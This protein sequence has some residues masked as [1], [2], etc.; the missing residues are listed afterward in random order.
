MSKQKIRVK[1][2][3]SIN[4]KWWLKQFPSQIPTWGECEFVF[5]INEKNYDWVVVY[6]DLPRIKDERFSKRTEKLTCRKDH[7]LLVTTEPPSIKSYGKIYVEQFGYVL[8]SHEDWALKH[9]EKIFSQ[10]ALIWFYGLGWHDKAVKKYD[11]MW[12][13]VDKHIKTE[14]ISTVCSSKQ[15]KHTLHNL[16][17][18]FTCELKKLIPELDIYGHGVKVINDKADA[19]DNYKYHIAIENYSGK[20]HWTEKLSDPFLGLC[21][22]FYYGATN[23]EDYF[24]KESFIE[25]DIYDIEKS[26]K[27]I[28]EAIKNNEYEKRL[29]QIKQAQK[30]VLNRYN[31]FVTVAKIIE[32]KN[33]KISANKKANGIISSRRAIMTSSPKN[34]LIHGYEKIRLGIVRRKIN[35]ASQ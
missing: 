6:D 23:V 7:S 10:P 30:L 28:K 4:E 12:R 32:E 13:G 2:I 5:D 26:A 3:S 9:N 18:K 33:D 8:T 34:F 14:E 20:N 27:I 29:E 11:N 21:L 24:P 35:K 17:Y 15:Q 19:L 31:F 25:I 16:R 22:P 1:I